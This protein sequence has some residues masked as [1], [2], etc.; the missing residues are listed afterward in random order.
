MNNISLAIGYMAIFCLWA[1]PTFGQAP[2]W[3]EY[4]G[5]ESLFPESRYVVGFASGSL[6]KKVP[7]EDQLQS[8]QEVAQRSLT[9]AIQTKIVS[10][11]EYE[12]ENIN[13]NSSE[14]FLYQSASESEVKLAGYQTE[15]FYDKRGKTLYAIAYVE[16]EPLIAYHESQI[17][18]GVEQ[19][20]AKLTEGKQHESTQQAA[21]AMISYYGCK[22][23][24]QEL[25]GSQLVLMALDPAR[26]AAKETR[27]FAS[28]AAQVDQSIESLQQ[29]P[30][31]NLHD[32]AE[33][34]AIACSLQ[35]AQLEA[36]MSMGEI[37]FEKTG[38]PSEFSKR[39]SAE[40]QQTLKQNAGF[41]FAE[42]SAIAF[43]G[44][45]WLEGDQV[46]VY[47]QIVNSQTG[48][49]LA[50]GDGRLP[51]Q[52]VNQQGWALVPS[53]YANLQALPALKLD[54]TAP[55]FPV[56]T[57]DQTE[58]PIIAQVS[59]TAGQSVDMEIF[60][61]IP[62]RINNLASTL[63]L[64]IAWTNEKGKAMLYT[65]DL[66]PSA[67]S[68]LLVAEIDLAKWFELEADDPYLQQLLENEKIPQSKFMLKISG[69]KVMLES[70]ELGT[71]SDMVAS[72][73][74][75]LFGEQGSTFTQNLDEAHY[76]VQIE[77]SY[78]DG[79]PFGSIHF[80]YADVNVT[81]IDT[82]HGEQQA[83]SFSD[84]KG[85][86]KT[87]EIARVKAYQEAGNKA[88]M[89]VRSLLFSRVK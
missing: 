3:I 41:D 29:V 49:V 64:P 62:I 84:V 80:A 75:K 82:R 76:V 89:W 37:S 68:Y 20:K 9:Q 15:R 25:Q 22:P 78:R 79:A 17:N 14:R 57:M 1:F 73:L 72:A 30:A 66:K 48:A 11:A 50:Q 47:G 59:K 71:D 2:S 7:V 10:K 31:H 61:N 38:Q 85:A 51:Q 70:N 39:L 88:A 5:R 32:L 53:F 6:Q 33:R 55:S 42:G 67:Q 86:G 56:S 69:P 8:L 43:Q 24:L 36:P 44:N 23:I 81:V 46:K 87:Y 12:L 77:G 40:C 34:I 21:L 83:R 54:V 27:A 13:A 28:L 65:P 26:D 63:D 4:Q 58:F 45:Y 16:I 60:N 52:W 35:I 19:I 74:K 18:Q